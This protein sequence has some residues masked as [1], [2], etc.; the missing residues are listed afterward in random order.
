MKTCLVRKVNMT[1]N[2]REIYL[3][4]ALWQ[5]P[6]ESVAFLFSTI[7]YDFVLPFPQRGILSWSLWHL[8]T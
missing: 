4:V 5:F 7:A 1:V 3:W 2:D 6:Q 8:W